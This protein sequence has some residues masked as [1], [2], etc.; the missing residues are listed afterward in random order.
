MYAKEENGIIKKYIDL[1]NSF[2]D[3]VGG[4]YKLDLETHKAD[5]F[6]PY[7]VPTIT[8][9][10][11]LTDI[12]FDE[13]NEVFTHD[14]VDFTAEEI[15]EFESN[16]AVDYIKNKYELHKSNGWNAY[17]DFRA[18]VVLDIESGTITETQAFIIESDLKIAYDRIAQNG[19]W[20]TAYFELSQIS[21]SYAFV[22]PYLDLALSYIA[23][24]IN[25]NYDS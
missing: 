23:N 16:K 25:L 8:E 2:G 22:Q 4:Y 14:V 9:Y 11:K 6:Y 10:Q 1:P 3:V 21:V 20:K 19:D 7:E 15:A 18:K 13:V 24:Y 5:D 12:Y 17:Q